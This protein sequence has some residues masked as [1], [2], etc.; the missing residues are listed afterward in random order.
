MPIYT[1]TTFISP[2]TAIPSEEDVARGLSR[3]PDIAYHTFE[4]IQN[5][6]TVLSVRLEVEPEENG[7]QRFHI[8]REWY[9][10]EQAQAH[11]NVN[12]EVHS[13]TPETPSGFVGCVVIT[14]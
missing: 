14:E 9:D 3:D 8:F 7:I 10:A 12:I 11:A 13:R 5:G 4:A 2:L 1:K 6:H